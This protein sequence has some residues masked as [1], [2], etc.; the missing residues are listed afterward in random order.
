MMALVLRYQAVTGALAF[1]SNNSPV[2]SIE[3]MI[4]ANLRANATAARLNPS[5]SFSAKAH[6][7]S[8]LVSDDLFKV[9]DAASYSSVRSL[10]SPRREM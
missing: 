4:T 1:G 8:A 3:C 2:F 7:L 6:V 9:T 10:A 5:R